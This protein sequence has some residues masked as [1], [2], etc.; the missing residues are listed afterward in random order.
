MDWKLKLK[1]LLHDP[2][3]KIRVIEKHKSEAVSLFRKILSESLEDE[4][5]NLADKLASSQSRIIVKP[6]FVDKQKERDFEKKSHVNYDECQ[7]VDIFSENKENIQTPDPKKV[8]DLFE[9]VG[10]LNFSNQEERA[11]LV[12]LFFWRFYLE[13]FPEINKQPADSRAP[14]HSIYDHLV[15]TSAIVS[16][17]SQ[18]AFLLFTIGPVQSFI[19]KARK[20]SDLWAG[21]YMLSYL[22]WESMKVLVEQY[23]PDVIIYPN[24]LGQPVV[25]RWLYEIFKN[26]SFANFNEIKFKEWF[27]KWENK[28]KELE[29]KLTIA[30]FPNRFLAIIPY[31]KDL[32][33]KCEVEFENKLK[34]LLQR[35]CDKI[36]NYYQNLN[37]K[38]DIEKHLLSYFQVYWVIMPWS[39]NDILPYDTLSDYRELFG[40]T[41][42]YN[43]IQ[44]IVDHPYYQPAN[45][46][47]AYSLILEITEKL[48]GTRKSVRDFKQIEQSGEKCHLCGEFEVLDIDWSQLSK[49]KPGIVKEWEKICGVCLTKR[50]FPEIIK[51]EL[52]LSED[53]RFP[54]TSEM[55]SIGEKRRLDNQIKEEFKQKFENFKSNKNLPSSI[56]VPKLKHDLLYE[57]DGQYL[58]EE[59]YRDEYFEREFGRKFDRKNLDEMKGFLR[60]KNINPSRYYAILQIDGDNMSKWLKGEFNPKIEN[61]IHE[62]VK[63]ALISFSEKKEKLQKILCSKHPTSPSIHQAF[64]R[65]IS[66][67]AL[68]K[69][70][71]IIENDHY[72]KLVYAGGDD[73][74]ALLPVEDV[75]KCAYNLQREF[76]NILSPKASMSAGILIVHHKYPLYMALKKVNEAEKKAKSIYGKDGKNSFCLIFLVGS[77][78]EREC[79]GNWELI[80][81]IEDLICKFRNDE[82]SG[83][84]PYQY[85]EVVEKLYNGDKNKNISNVKEILRNE[86]IR[87]FIRKE[88]VDK[89]R[90]KQYFEEK[91]LPFFE[92]L[93]INNFA[94]MLVIA[95]RISGEMRI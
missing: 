85:L 26:S 11:K 41:E 20:T 95:E 89:A 37:L 75:L 74:L 17:L 90:L 86:L 22:I 44:E 79:G 87:I 55:G 73:V 10:E 77:G 48:L 36:K 8:Q 93:E 57:I 63:D 51:E 1:A 35:V 60:E 38:N 53:I 16:A 33:K 42:L 34:N 5:V 18:P 30:N 94:S 19:S 43:I 65:R 46:G 56:S 88:G 61:T 31:N 40:E 25:D 80:D 70:R 67:F 64:S 12:F 84:F 66:Q 28:D 71:K 13:I 4:S 27:Q 32:G 29:E 52:N 49:D 21:S 47:S 72:G 24:L 7:F 62:K 50:L 14:N 39:K 45:V 23:G 76:K 81:F 15:Q 59:T 91:I 9:K 78:A 92:K 54:S 69:V 68:E 2:P 3:Y 83:V 6:N 58:M 82:I